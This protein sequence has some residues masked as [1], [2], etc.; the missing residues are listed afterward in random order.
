MRQSLAAHLPMWYLSHFSLQPIPR[1]VWPVV[2]HP[3]FATIVLSVWFVVQSAGAKNSVPPTEDTGPESV[4][5]WLAEV[6]AVVRAHADPVRRTIVCRVPYTDV[7][8]TSLVQATKVSRHNIMR[9]AARLESMNLV[10]ISN[11]MS[12]QWIIQPA[13][14]E[15]REKMKRWAETWCVGDDD[16]GPQK[17]RRVKK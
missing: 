6:E 11:N 12:G 7:V 2:Q 16:C 5:A 3:L 15:A 9:A 10:K 4:A 8:I 1:I 17:K 14:E 13:S